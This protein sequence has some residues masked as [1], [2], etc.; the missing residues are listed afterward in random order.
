MQ[1]RDRLIQSELC[2]FDGREHRI[3]AI[4]IYSSYIK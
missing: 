4:E 3:E 2:D 1:Q